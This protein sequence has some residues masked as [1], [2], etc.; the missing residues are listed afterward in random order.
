ML[1]SGLT[2]ASPASTPSS[3]PV[4]EAFAPMSVTM[5]LADDID[6][7]R[8]DMICRPAQQADGRPGPRRHGVL[9]DRRA[10]SRWATSCIKHTTRW[11][12]AVVTDLHYRLD[13][14]T[15]HRDE[16]P[17]ALELNEVGR[18]SLRDPAAVSTTRTA[19]TGHRL[20]HPG[21]RG[22]QRHRRG[23]H[24]PRPV[25]ASARA[26]SPNTVRHQSL[27]TRRTTART[28]RAPCGS[29]GS[30]ARASRPWP[31][32]SSSAW[33]TRPAAYRLDGDN[34]RTAS[35]PTSASR[36][37]GRELRRV[38]EVATLFADAG[39]VA[40]GRRSAPTRST[41]SWRAQVHGEAGLAFVEVFVDTPLEDCERRDP[42][43]LYAKARAGEITD[44]TGIDDPYERPRT[45]TC[46]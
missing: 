21:R 1:P 29:P 25:P 26:A 30:P 6:V 15:L 12:R 22:H 41:G 44:F 24:A 45:R 46:V 20:V 19:A 4:E 2:T 13:V 33:S 23:R 42:K 11:V 9:D 38:A 16:A 3:G 28:G 18:V 32:P 31:P 8:G 10:R 39:L 34:L 27:V 40:G 37:T 14:N 17:T 5:R 7:S 43:G 35:T 36:P